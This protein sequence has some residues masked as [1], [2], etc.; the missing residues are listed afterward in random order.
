MLNVPNA[1]TLLRVALVPVIATLL[2]RGRHDAA[3][4]LFIVSALSDLADGVIAR[5]WN[6]RTR[7]GAIA[8]PLADKLT[9]VTV[10]LLLFWLQVVPV[11]FAAA[12][13]LRD[14]TIVAGALAYHWQVGRV[15]MEPSAVSKVNTALEFTSLVAAL[16]VLAER[17]PGGPW[18]QVLFGI[19][20]ATI[21][22]SGA[23]YV[24]VWSRK[25]R[26]ARAA[27]TIRG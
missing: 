21:V 12:V 10:T 6:L 19:T 27:R 20:L 13:L 5:R 24:V 11:W 15:E 17:L 8:D 7:F 23:H 18:L 26:A 2:L 9:M 16:A 25:A 22:W 4:V 14:A 3:L 1:I